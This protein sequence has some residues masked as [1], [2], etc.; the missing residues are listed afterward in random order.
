MFAVGIRY[1]LTPFNVMA[2]VKL[3]VRKRT[4]NGIK[5]VPIITKYSPPKHRNTRKALPKAA[6]KPSQG[7]G[8]SK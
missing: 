4:P 1:S 2:R 6:Q 8:T 3:Y 5:R 7:K